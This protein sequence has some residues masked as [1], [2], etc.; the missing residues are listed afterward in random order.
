MYLLI[1]IE[2]FASTS[3]K[4]QRGPEAMGK[5]DNLFPRNALLATTPPESQHM[6][7]YV[8]GEVTKEAREELSR[9]AP[10]SASQCRRRHRAIPGAEFPEHVQLEPR[11]VPIACPCAAR[12]ANVGQERHASGEA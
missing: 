10:T 4:A 9:A 11:R 5:S 7:K 2:K 3:S 6:P 1:I 8:R 12:R